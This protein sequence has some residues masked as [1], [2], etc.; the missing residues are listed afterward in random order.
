MAA[1]ATATAEE[2][3]EVAAAIVGG[4][5]TVAAMTVGGTTVAVMIAAGVMTAA[6]EAA[7]A[8]AAEVVAAVM[9]AVAAVVAAVME[10]LRGSAA[11]R[12]ATTSARA[13]TGTSPPASS[14]CRPGRK[15]AAAVS[16]TRALARAL[17]RH[18]RAARVAVR[19]SIEDAAEGCGGRL[20]ETARVAIGLGRL[21]ATTLVPR[22]EKGVATALFPTMDRANDLSVASACSRCGRDKAQHRPCLVATCSPSPGFHLMAEQNLNF[23]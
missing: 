11:A 7:A 10:A 3:M 14:S 16:G 20:D 22:L 2:D 18:P 23:G 9:E 19:A 15:K 21:E 4:T 5:I 1:V 8:A 17:A 12:A 6:T 13:A